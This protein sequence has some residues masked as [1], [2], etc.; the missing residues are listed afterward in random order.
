MVFLIR[1]IGRLASSSSRPVSRSLFTSTA[2]ARRPRA[3]SA[4]SAAAAVPA[5]PLQN[6]FG[7]I[8]TLTGKREK[9]KA[10]LV[11]YDGGQHAKDVSLAFLLL[12]QSSLQF[13]RTIL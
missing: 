8:R 4:R 1:S 10:L 13:G 3:A 7:S 2:A 12:T 5:M 6:G 11:L 9:V